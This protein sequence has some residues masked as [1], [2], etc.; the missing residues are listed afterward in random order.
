LEVTGGESTPVASKILMIHA[1][2]EEICD[3]LLATM[4][5]IRE[6]STRLHGEV[7]EH[8]KRRKVAELRSAN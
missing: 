5:M 8:E 7:I 4:R 6:T 3:S 2:L 1:T